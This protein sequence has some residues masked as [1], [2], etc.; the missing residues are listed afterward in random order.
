MKLANFLELGVS[1]IFLI[2]RT[3][4]LQNKN[5]KKLLS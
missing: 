4:C 3:I 2:L 1:I 5:S